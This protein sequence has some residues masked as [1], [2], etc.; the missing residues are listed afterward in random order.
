MRDQARHYFY[1]VL[2][3]SYP[4][5]SKEKILT[6]CKFLN[7]EFRQTKE[8]LSV[9]TMRLS[10]KI[11]SKYDSKGALISCA[12]YVNSDYF[13]RRECVTFNEDGFIG[14]C[15]WASDA[16]AKPIIQAFKKWCDDICC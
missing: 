16:N 1:N 7:Q 6:L 13:T 10:R 15:G 9:G 4:E 12:L 2:N 3:L 8:P 5:L 14:F 11:K